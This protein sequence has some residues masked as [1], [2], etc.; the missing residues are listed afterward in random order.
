MCKNSVMAISS[1]SWVGVDGKLYLM[2]NR[3]KRSYSNDDRIMA[4]YDPKVNK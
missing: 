2:N 4:C 3:E 1:L